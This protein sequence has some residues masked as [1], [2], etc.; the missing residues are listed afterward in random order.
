MNYYNL[1]YIGVPYYKKMKGNSGPQRRKKNQ[2]IPRHPCASRRKRG[3]P[4]AG[5][6]L[7]SFSCVP[8]MPLLIIMR[9][10]YTNI[11][12]KA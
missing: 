11:L 10:P 1:C 2:G 8:H 6:P 3:C 12:A 9:N 4:T 7:I 5:P